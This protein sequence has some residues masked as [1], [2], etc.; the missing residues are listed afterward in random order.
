MYNENEVIEN[1]KKE[2][3]IRFGLLSFLILAVSTLCIMVPHVSNGRSAAR[4]KYVFFFIGD[5]MGVAQRTIAEYYTTSVLGEGELEFNHL[6][7]VGMYS[8]SSSDSLVPDSAATATAMSTGVDTDNAQINTDPDTEEDDMVH[9]GEGLHKKGIPIGIVTTTRVTHA[10]PAAFSSHAVHRDQEDKIAVEQFDFKPELLVGGGSSYFIPVSE[11]GSNRKDNRN[12]LSEFEEEGYSVYTDMNTF[13]AKV[14]KDKKR[15]L[16]VLNSSHIPYV[17]DR[18]ENAQGLDEM[19]KA[20]IDHMYNNYKTGFFMMI[21]G[22]RIDHAAH[23]NDTR[24]MIEE[25]REFEKSIQHALSFYKKHRNETLILVGADHETGGLG[26]GRGDDY[27]VN[28]DT[29]QQYKGSGEVLLRGY[30]KRHMDHK[31]VLSYLE[32]EYGLKNLTKEEEAKLEVIMTRLDRIAP[33]PKKGYEGILPEEYAYLD[34]LEAVV[35]DIV[36]ERAGIG[37]STHAHTGSFVE[38]TAIGKGSEE[39]S[40]MFTNEDIGQKL[41]QL[42]RVKVQGSR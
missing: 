35:Y 4:P 40:D 8:T 37:Y 26:I 23:N 28:L 6:D 25:T 3:Y 5:G 14:G 42:L 27:F 34:P 18:E 31:K 19:T 12:V 2:K 20:S 41:A 39:F 36:N 21:E 11:Q 10:T 30:Y 29:L 15:V 16:G 24:T 17:V 1:M 22:G 38:A 13:T 33:D 7:E 32:K 9:L